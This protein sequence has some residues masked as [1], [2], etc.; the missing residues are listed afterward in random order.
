[1][2]GNTLCA[3]SPT[4]GE[5]GRVRLV[6][7]EKPNHVGPNRSGTAHASCENRD[8]SLRV[9]VPAASPG[10]GD[11]AEDAPAETFGRRLVVQD[12]GRSVLRS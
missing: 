12:A 5:S 7:E 8:I 10:W 2:T 6:F 1:M 9:V 11:D 4:R 3:S